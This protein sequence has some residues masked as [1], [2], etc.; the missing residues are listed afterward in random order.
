MGTDVRLGA[1]DGVFTVAGVR[2]AR[3]GMTISRDAGLG[4]EN[5]VTF[6]ALG[7]GTSIS[8]DRYDMTSMYIGALGEA[9]FLTGDDAGRQSFLDGDM[10]IVPGGTLCG[11]ESGSGAVYTEIII[12][13]EI[14]MNNLVKAGEVMKLK[15][16]IQ[17]EEESI[18]NLDVVSN[19]TMKFVLMAF[20]EGTGLQPHRAPGNAIIF[21]LEGKAVIGYEGKDYTISAGENF[22]FEKNGLHSV[23]ADG[24]FKMA[25]LLVIE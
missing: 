19:P 2:P 1:M 5:T 18:S 23:T 14:N 17:Y 9:V 15:N 13:K 21:A 11:V 10:L 20:D 6:F 3:D 22:R 24:K 16:L 7:A 8:R 4:S 12:K 25:L